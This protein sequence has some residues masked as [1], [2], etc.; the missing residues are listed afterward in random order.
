MDGESPN[1]LIH[2]RGAS[3]ITIVVCLVLFL[4][5]MKDLPYYLNYRKLR[6]FAENSIIFR[7]IRSQGD[8]NKLVV[9]ESVSKWEQDWL[10]AFHPDTHKKQA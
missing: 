10:I 8:C 6:L 2:F 4:A 5:L 3:R 1:T 7:S 9:L